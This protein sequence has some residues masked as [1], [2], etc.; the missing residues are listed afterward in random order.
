MFSVV[1]PSLHAPQID[2][3]VAALQAQTARQHI[4]EIIVV[5]LDRH[6]LVPADVT[7][8]STNRPV[9]AAVA[10]NRGARYATG[11]V[12]LFIDSDCVAAPDLIERLLVHYAAGRN[13]VG[14]SVALGGDDYWMQC[15]HMLI[16]AD[17]LPSAPAGERVFLPSGN[18]SIRRELFLSLGG[19]DQGFPGAAGEEVDL[20][21]RLREHGQQLYFEPRA[22]VAHCHP[23]ISPTIV[24]NHL[25]RFGQVQVTQWRRHPRL[26]PP[27]FGGRLHALSSL[28]LA[29]APLL[30]L[31]DV[32]RIFAS[33]QVALV[34]LHLLPGMVWARTAWYW[35]IAE[36]IL[37]QP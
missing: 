34:Y 15:D 10:R 2:R 21:L 37:A 12:V 3:V 13:V 25:R 18:C 16:F 19:F 14:G 17:F 20:C 22:C 5:G 4:H 1:I 23:R 24:W 9:S 27:P 33:A 11:E 30:A 31:A 32:L 35:G 28:L 8:L 36:A 26:S 6:G 29:W 7:F